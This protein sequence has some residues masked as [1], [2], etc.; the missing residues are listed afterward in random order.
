MPKLIAKKK[1]WLYRINNKNN[2][3]NY[4]I[5]KK[6]LAHCRAFKDLR[7]KCNFFRIKTRS[8]PLQH[9]IWSEEKRQ[10]H[11]KSYT[12]KTNLSLH[13]M[14]KIWCNLHKIKTWS[15]CILYIDTSYYNIGI[16]IYPFPRWRQHFQKTNNKPP[17]TTNS[18]TITMKTIAHGGKTAETHDNRNSR[19]SKDRL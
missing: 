11:R 6:T 1:H 12:C 7:A 4:T 18:I 10:I 19:Q 8:S 17:T 2:W 14:T 5:F 9:I 15:L 3:R 16:E 13:D